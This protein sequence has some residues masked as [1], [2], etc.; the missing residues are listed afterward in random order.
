ML[1]TQPLRRTRSQSLSRTKPDTIR[2]AVADTAITDAGPVSEELPLLRLWNDAEA[3]LVPKP[4]SL[5]EIAAT[6]ERDHTLSQYVGQDDARFPA[7]FAG[8]MMSDQDVVQWLQEMKKPGKDRKLLL[9]D[10]VEVSFVPYERSVPVANVAKIVRSFVNEEPLQQRK[11]VFQGHLTDYQGLPRGIDAYVMDCV[12]HFVKRD[13]PVPRY[14]EQR[15]KIESSVIGASQGEEKQEHSAPVDCPRSVLKRSYDQLVDSTGSLDTEAQNSRYD[16]MSKSDGARQKRRRYHTDNLSTVMS[17]GSMSSFREGQSSSVQLSQPIMDKEE[18]KFSSQKQIWRDIFGSDTESESSRQDGVFRHRLLKSS[19]APSKSL[20]SHDSTDVAHRPVVD[21][22]PSSHAATESRARPPRRR[23]II[24]DVSDSEDSLF[25]DTL[26]S[27]LRG[28]VNTGDTC[29]IEKYEEEEAQHQQHLLAKFEQRNSGLSLRS[30]A[31]DGVENLLIIDDIWQDD[32]DPYGKDLPLPLRDDMNHIDSESVGLCDVRELMNQ[33]RLLV[34]SKS[35]DD[36]QQDEK[37]AEGQDFLSIPRDDSSKSDGDGMKISSDGELYHQPPPKIGFGCMD[38]IERNK[39]NAQSHAPPFLSGYHNRVGDSGKREISGRGVIQ[40]QPQLVATSEAV[41]KF[42]Q[43]EAK[44]QLLRLPSF[45]RGIVIRD[46]AGN[47]ELPGCEEKMHQPQSSTRPKSKNSALPA[48]KWKDCEHENLTLGDGVRRDEQKAQSRALPSLLAANINTGND[49][50]TRISNGKETKH[51]SQPLVECKLGSSVAT[52]ERREEREDD[53]SLVANGIQK[54]EPG[55]HSEVEHFEEMPSPRKRR[56]RITNQTSSRQSKRNMTNPAGTDNYPLETTPY[57]SHVYIWNYEKRKRSSKVF[58]LRE[59]VFLC[60]RDKHVGIYDGQDFDFKKGKF[61]TTLKIFDYD[62]AKWGQRDE[63]ISKQ[64]ARI[65]VWDPIRRGI[66]RFQYSPTTP[67]LE[68]WL[69]I[70]TDYAVFEPSMLN[71]SCCPI[72]DNN[73]TH[74]QSVVDPFLGVAPSRPLC[75]QLTARVRDMKYANLDLKTSVDYTFWNTLKRCKERRKPFKNTVQLLKFWLATPWLEIYRGQDRVEEFEAQTGLRLIPI[76]ATCPATFASFWDR[77]ARRKHIRPEQGQMFGDKTI[78]QCLVEHPNLDLYLGQDTP[79]AEYLS[80]AV[81]HDRVQGQFPYCYM[82]GHCGSFACHFFSLG[83]VALH[84]DARKLSTACAVFWNKETKSLEMQPETSS[85]VSIADYLQCNSGTVE[86]YI[87]QDLKDE[88][89]TDISKWFQLLTFKPGYSSKDDVPLVTKQIFLPR[90][91]LTKVVNSHD[92]LSV[93]ERKKA[94]KDTRCVSTA[95]HRMEMKHLS[96][97]RGESPKSKDTSMERGKFSSG[98]EHKVNLSMTERNDNE[99]KSIVKF[100]DIHDKSLTKKCK[101]ATSNI[102]GAGTHH[103]NLLVGSIENNKRSRCVTSEGRNSAAAGN[104]SLRTNLLSS[105]RWDV[106][107]RLIFGDDSAAVETNKIRK[108]WTFKVEGNDK[109]SAGEVLAEPNVDR[110]V[111]GTLADRIAA[112]VK[113]N[114]K[115]L[116]EKSHVEVQSK[117][118]NETVVQKESA[119]STVKNAGGFMGEAQPRANPGTAERSG[120]PADSSIRLKVSHDQ[121]FAESQI[122]SGSCTADPQG[123]SCAPVFVLPE[124]EDRRCKDIRLRSERKASD[125]EATACDHDNTERENK[126]GLSKVVS[127]QV[128]RSPVD[129]GASS[130]APSASLAHGNCEEIRDEREN[131]SGKHPTFLD[132]NEKEITERPKEACA[133]AL[134]GKGNYCWPSVPPSSVEIELV[135]KK[136]KRAQKNEVCEN[137]ILDEPLHLEEQ[138]SSKELQIELDLKPNAQSQDVQDLITVSKEFLNESSEGCATTLECAAA[139]VDTKLRGFASTLAE[140]RASFERLRPEDSGLK[141]NSNMQK[142]DAQDQFKVLRELSGK[143]ELTTECTTTTIGAKL[144]DSAT[145]TAVKEASAVWSCQQD[146]RSKSNL[147]PR[148]EGLKERTSPSNEILTAFKKDTAVLAVADVDTKLEGHV[149]A[150]TRDDAAPDLN[151]SLTEPRKSQS[152]VEGKE[153]EYASTVVNAGR[154][155]P[156]AA[157][158][159]EGA[160]FSAH[161]RPLINGRELNSIIQ[162]DS[163][164]KPII[165]SEDFSNRPNKKHGTE[166]TC[167]TASEDSRQKDSTFRSSAMEAPFSKNERQPEKP[168]AAEQSST[169]VEPP[170]LLTRGEEDSLPVAVTGEVIRTKQL[171]A[172]LEDSRTLGCNTPE[173]FVHKKRDSKALAESCTGD[174]PTSLAEIKRKDAKALVVAKELIASEDAHSLSESEKCPAKL[175]SQESKE[176]AIRRK[177]IDP[178]DLK[179]PKHDVSGLKDIVPDCQGLVTP[180][181]Q[182]TSIAQ[183]PEQ[184]I[185]EVVSKKGTTC[186]P[187]YSFIDSGKV[188]AISC[189]DKEQENMAIRE[190]VNN[191]IEPSKEVERV[192]PSIS[193]LAKKTL[194]SR[195]QEV[196]SAGRTKVRQEQ[197]EKEQ[198]VLGGR[199]LVSKAQTDDAKQPILEASVDTT[200]CSEEQPSVSTPGPSTRTPGSSI[201]EQPDDNIE[202]DDDSMVS[203]DFEL[204]TVDI[205]DSGNVLTESRLLKAR[206]E[207]IKMANLIRR[208]GPKILNRQLARDTRQSLREEMLLETDN[209][210]ALITLSKRLRSPEFLIAAEDLCGRL[211]V[212]DTTGCFLGTSDYEYGPLDLASIREDLMLGRIFTICGVIEKFRLICGDLLQFHDGS[213]LYFEAALLKHNGEEVIHAFI[214][215]NHKLVNEERQITRIGIICHKAE[216]IGFREE[217]GGRSNES[218]DT[219]SPSNGKPTI[220]VSGYQSEVTFLNYRDE[221]GNSVMGKRHSARVLGLSIDRESCEKKIDNVQPCHICKKI[222]FKSTG[223]SLQC[224]NNVVGLC[225]VIVCRECLAAVFSMKEPDFICRRQANDWI[226]IHCKGFCQKEVDGFSRCERK[227]DQVAD[228]EVLLTWPHESLNARSVSLKLLRRSLAGNFRAWKYSKTCKLSKVDGKW[229]KQTRLQPGVYR[230]RVEVNEKWIACTVIHVLSEKRRCEDTELDMSPRAEGNDGEL[231]SSA[232]KRQEEV[233]SWSLSEKTAKGPVHSF[234]E[235]DGGA[236]MKECSRTEGYDWRRSKHHAVVRWIPKREVKDRQKFRMNGPSGGTSG[237]KKQHEVQVVRMSSSC[238]LG[239]CTVEREDFPKLRTGV[240]YEAFRR[241]VVAFKYDYMFNETLKGIV[242]GKSDIHGIGLFTLTGYQKG[243]FVIEYAGDLIRSPLADIRERRYDAAGLGTYLFRIDDYK[244]VDAT[245]NSNRARF[246]NHS[247]DP[248]MEADIVNVRGRDLVVLLATRDIPPFSELTFNY[249]LPYEDKKLQCLCNSWNCIGVMN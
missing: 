145:M 160:T 154:K 202:S 123:D 83:W 102:D 16:S 43:D 242:M 209:S 244:I 21:F 158:T 241:A 91:S 61:A 221:K 45:S 53:D 107:E 159:A 231:M 100:R 219:K 99:K 133:R 188:L 148:E 181:Q 118:L 95:L 226:C 233:V 213:V 115:R 227:D 190:V 88:I 184:N 6:L 94:V 54:D 140:Q 166:A 186:L 5:G 2:S 29:D 81:E 113:E 130:K 192:T 117:T 200:N 105:S 106:E 20:D 210:K 28:D 204:Q 120:F 238:A 249:Q 137:G 157:S 220:R 243:D 13:A 230:C 187:D 62:H 108:E 207:A 152:E 57:S 218:T 125:V 46:D 56:R 124:D 104:D 163:V 193:E 58:V 171:L 134:E 34:E 151:H 73:R 236:L 10:P 47:L 173:I 162:K 165:A 215:E 176:R 66:R 172:G 36:V 195:K 205:N 84:I 70:H 135:P 232:M 48:M 149:V 169:F 1:P 139:D 60:E 203:G 7:C 197:D 174:V 49:N 80:R 194:V 191:L 85:F 246:T 196:L 90:K 86:L 245:V 177:S 143:K 26:A 180:R 126:T 131:D 122:R 79:Y 111:R 138:G 23:W 142:Q 92:V 144:K 41:G 199:Q 128:E 11:R 3:R 25:E 76:H 37:E 185:I 87:G 68:E 155:E 14:R 201:A 19:L 4:V 77:V 18:E 97:K 224:L 52:S 127:E 51:Q 136:W 32:Q 12:N 228:V 89:R 153:M 22:P 39:Q 64:K 156:V 71:L 40:G 225:D 78:Y 112:P 42:G 182:C 223:D 59:A 72:L 119:V 75:L 189:Q 237:R 211:E 63:Q 214:S 229:S 69:K 30:R 248:N 93:I 150:L 168:S 175:S 101:T 103:S 239:S 67:H 170:L 247:C 15:S 217:D 27:N 178:K 110:S 116:S 50:D 208:A 161:V 38:E 33:P 206:K 240:S 179:K 212:L 167:A 98:T 8:K 183:N 146:S 121:P 17:K 164:R 114:T 216:K 9:I 74:G 31:N 109:I 147:S 132:Q 44:A 35:A 235:N 96:E 234:S 82:L 55:A 24:I 198:K 65:R 141:P 129:N 222:V